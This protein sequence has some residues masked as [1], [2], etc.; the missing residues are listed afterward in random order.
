MVDSMPLLRLL[1]LVPHEVTQDNSLDG[2]SIDPFPFVSNTYCNNRTTAEIDE[3][4]P[5]SGCNDSR[6][7]GMHSCHIGVCLEHSQD[8]PCTA[9]C[10]ILLNSSHLPQSSC[11]DTEGRCR[12]D[13]HPPDAWRH[14]GGGLSSFSSHYSLYLPRSWQNSHAPTS[15]LVQ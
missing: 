7:K 12:E 6:L 15:N 8:V 14:R 4:V 5:M 1:D 11:R 3:I 10:C 9:Q 2:I 13:L